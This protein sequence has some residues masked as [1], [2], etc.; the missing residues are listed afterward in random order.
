MPPASASADL[1]D[2]A[3]A[4]RNMRQ[5]QGL[6]QRELAERMRVPRTYVSKIENDKA[7]PTLTSLERMAT[8]MDTSIATLLQCTGSGLPPAAVRELLSDG[9]VRQ[10]VPIVPLLAPEQMNMLVVELRQLSQ[11]RAARVQ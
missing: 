6:S 1:P 11:R 7:T 4:I 8:A 10:L 3:G 5:R 9:F 2:V